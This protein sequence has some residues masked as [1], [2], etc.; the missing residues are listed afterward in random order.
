MNERSLRRMQWNSQRFAAKVRGIE[1][2]LTF[3]E[4]LSVW[5]ESG[6]LCFR[7]RKPDDYVMARHGDV[8]PYK[9]GNVKIIRMRENC[10]EVHI[11]KTK[12]V[13]GWTRTNG[14]Y[15]VTAFRKYVGFYKTQAEAEQAYLA[16]RRDVYEKRAAA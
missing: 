3:E 13:R 1:W 4:W 14:G 9:V 6:K 8:G 11:H 2:D 12:P 10:A 16:V 7:G 15:Q 5:H